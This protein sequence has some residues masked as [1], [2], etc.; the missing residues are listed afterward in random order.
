M[1]GRNWPAYAWSFPLGDGR[2]NVGYGELLTGRAPTRA[3]MLD[4]MRELLPGLDPAPTRLRAHRLPLSPG[5]P[6]VADGRVLLAGDALSLINPLSGEGDLLCGPVR[7]TRRPGRRVWCGCRRG[8]TVPD[9]DDR[10]A[11][12]SPAGHRPCRQVG[13]G[14]TAHRRR[15]QGRRFKPGGLRRSHPSGSGRWAR[16]LACSQAWFCAS[17]PDRRHRARWAAARVPATSG[18]R[19]GDV[20]QPVHAELVGHMPKVSPQGAV[21]SGTVIV[22]PSGASPSSRAARPR[23]RR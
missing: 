5:R 18:W 9:A 17:R 4:R 21:L 20:H 12:T 11:R 1:Y 6:A 22:A 2:A 16:L 15:D 3:A 7:R 10:S 23:P 13:P 8:G 14:A 19:P